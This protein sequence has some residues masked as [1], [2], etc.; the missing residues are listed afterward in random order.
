MK[1]IAITPEIHEYITT[2]FPAENEFL[3]ELNR[4]A[5]EQGIPPIN[6]T[7]EQLA[8]IQMLLRALNAKYVME[9]GS[10]A[11]YSAIGMAS[12]LP[13]DGKLVAFE[14]NPRHA[15]FI[16]RK[17]AEA[18]LDHKIQLHIGDAKQLLREFKPHHEFDF[19]F[20]DAEKAGYT[21][22]LEFAVPMLRVG[23][24]VAGDN[25]L[26]WGKI[27]DPTTEDETVQA[28]QA[29]NC[30]MSKHDQL[31]ACLIPLAEGMTLGT[32]IR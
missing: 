4:E 17:A 30:A 25:T 22:Y 16:H 29:F 5:K 28:L 7:A 3:R 11:G 24:I 23:G 32:R 18:K 27:A 13:D 21:A 12:V 19:V 8:F 14:I 10:L 2:L 20:I 6:I 26:A 15:E 1:Y 31:Q 9:I